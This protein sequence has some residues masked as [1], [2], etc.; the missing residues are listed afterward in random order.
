MR[1][2]L[3]IKSSNQV[4]RHLTLNLLSFTQI[5]FHKPTTAQ[6]QPLQQSI[7]FKI[8]NIWTPMFILG[9][10]KLSNL[11]I[12]T[13]EIHPYV[14]QDIGLC[15]TFTPLLQLNTTSNLQMTSSLSLPLHQCFFPHLF[16]FPPTS[17]FFTFC[18]Y[19]TFSFPQQI[20]TSVVSFMISNK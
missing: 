18:C 9:L 6:T 11:A 12:S 2:Y 4:I 8:F 7:S 15:P 3:T 14:Q 20:N 10:L 5:N 13:E 16:L 19:S 1:L 17:H